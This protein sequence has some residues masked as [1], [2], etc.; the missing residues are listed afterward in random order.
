MTN[1]QI[2]AVL[3]LDVAKATVEAQL[4]QCRGEAT[5]RFC[6]SNDCAGFNKLGAVLIGHGC[7]KVHAGLEAT[8]PYSQKLALW[9]HQ[10]GHQINML[11]PRRVKD[12]ARSAGTRNKSDSIDAELIAKFIFAHLEQCRRTLW[13]PAKAE[14]AQLQGLVRRREEICVLIVAEKNRLHAAT[15]LGVCDSVARLLDALEREKSHLDQLIAQQI[16]SHSTL[17]RNEQLLCTITGVGRVTAAVLLAEMAG[18]DRVTRARQAAAHAGLSP[19]REQSGT[20]VRRN[21]GIGH[22][23]NRHLRKALYLPAVVAIKHNPLLRHF[24]QRLAANG[25]CKMAIV[26]AVMRKLIHIAFGVLKHQQPFN[27]S[28]A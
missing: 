3:G 5:V 2:D 9:L 11:N 8:G 24:A 12:Y 26:C 7:K 28:L 1:E 25:K 17:S 6:F 18:P 20:S 21:K 13:R 14:V 16:R 10:Q 15:T 19:R 22:Q 27:P 4:R 23:G